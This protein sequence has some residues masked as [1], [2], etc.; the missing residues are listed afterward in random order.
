MRKL[1]RDNASSTFALALL[2]GLSMFVGAC[3]HAN[4][5]DDS[6][7]SV[8]SSDIATRAVPSTGRLEG[9]EDDDD[10][11][12][13]AGTATVHAQHDNDADGDNDSPSKENKSYRDKDDRAFTTWGLPADVRDERAV[14]SLVKRYYG[15]AAVGDGAKACALTYVLFAEAIPEDYGQP[16]GPPALRGKTCAEVLTKLFR[17]EQGKLVAENASIRVTGVRVRG[18]QGRAL[19]GFATAPASY[20]QMHRERGVW[21]VVGPLAVT[22]P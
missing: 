19:L 4:K 2:T 14:A 1:K 11:A 10:E 22:L 7:S 3:G 15:I 21:R 17:L 16:P 9:D 12:S 13:A 20:L 6:T 8:A 18:N 5:S